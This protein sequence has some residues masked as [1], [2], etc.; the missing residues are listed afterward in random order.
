MM[1]LHHGSDYTQIEQNCQYFMKKIFDFLK[2][3]A[4]LSNGKLRLPTVGDMQVLI[5]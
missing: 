1:I 5:G 4:I 2:I 3:C